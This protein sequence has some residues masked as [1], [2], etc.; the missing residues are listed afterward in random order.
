MDGWGR[1]LRYVGTEANTRMSAPFESLLQP[2]IFH[3]AAPRIIISGIRFLILCLWCQ[4]QECSVLESALFK[5]VKV[6][7][8]WSKDDQECNQSG[9][10]FGCSETV[11]EPEP[12][13][14]W[15]WVLHSFLFPDHSWTGSIPGSKKLCSADYGQD[16]LR[17]SQ[18]GNMSLSPAND[19]SFSRTMFRSMVPN[20]A[21]HK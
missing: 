2:G 10:S 4:T 5:V 16:Q 7:G 11:P 6:K 3:N 14:A 8:N 9:A 15:I 18:D 1:W 21:K 19:P 20:K 17:P 12:F 13:Q